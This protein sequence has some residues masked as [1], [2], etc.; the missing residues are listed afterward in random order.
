MGKL[1]LKGT[2]NICGQEVKIVEG[3]FGEGQKI[4]FDVQVANVHEV[5]PSY[6]RGRAD[7]LIEKGIFKL[8]EDYIKRSSSGEDLLKEVYSSMELSQTTECYIFSEQ[9]Y[10][11]LVSAMSN[12]NIKKWEVMGAFISNYFK[13]RE[14]IKNQTQVPM[15]QAPRTMKEAL[16]LALQL[17]EEKEELQLENGK[18]QDTI[19]TVAPTVSAWDRFMNSKGSFAIKQFADAINIRGLGR[20]N[21]FA[22]LKQNGILDV[23][24]NPYR[25]YIDSGYFITEPWERG[26]RCGMATKVTPKGVDWLYKKLVKEGY[27]ISRPIEE[28][29]KSLES[30]ENKSEETKMAFGMTLEQERALRG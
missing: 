16:Q 15:I 3:G 23:Y 22:W 29:I 20:N 9:G 21:M 25:R 12:A 5:T 10:I 13:M 19:D 4:L 6:I 30:Q 24:N 1:V 27:I 14:E 11:K 28:I 7:M 17:E 26:N 8:G 18:L 2:T